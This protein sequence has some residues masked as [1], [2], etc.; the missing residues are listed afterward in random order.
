MTT[1]MK[2]SGSKPLMTS[3][4]GSEVRVSP[5][6]EHARMCISRF[7]QDSNH[8]PH[9]QKRKLEPVEKG[10]HSDGSM[11][12]VQSIRAQP[13]APVTQSVY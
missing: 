8:M 10:V 13:K 5:P 6:P 12:E 2:K 9:A 4:A 1:R 11:A 3:P 7:E